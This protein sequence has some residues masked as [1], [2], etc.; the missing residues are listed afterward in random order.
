[1]NEIMGVKLTNGD[2]LIGR[3]LLDGDGYITE[4]A[5]VL[6]V[7]STP[8]GPVAAL[9]PWLITASEH[10]EIRLLKTAMLAQ[11]FEVSKAVHDDYIKQTT[12]IVLAT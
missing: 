7:M 1:M 4:K 2:E 6:R 12:G 5:R 3:L 9:M 10:A 8:D 11:P